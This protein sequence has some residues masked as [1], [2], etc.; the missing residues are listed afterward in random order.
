[1]SDSIVRPETGPGSVTHLI[2]VHCDPSTLTLTVSL[3]KIS[4]NPG[5][6]VVW[7]FLGIPAGWTPWIEFRQAEDN[8]FVGPLTG[9]TQTPGGIWGVCRSTGWPGTAPVP[10]DYRAMIQRGFADGWDT[11]GSIAWSAPARLDVLPS[12]IGQELFYNV[13]RDTGPEQLVV[14][15][16]QQTLGPSDVIVWHFPNDLP[17]GVEAW[18]PRIKL[19]RYEGTGTVVNEQLGP[20]AALTVLPGKLR[21]TG[22]SGVDGLYFFEV[23][24]VSVATGQ[25][26]W[27]S[28]GDPVIDNRGGVSTPD[29][30]KKPPRRGPGKPRT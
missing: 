7:S 22:N 4:L 23:A 9:L 2:P 14:E 18:R 28:S 3:P 12:A 27:M 1:M 24:L 5:D 13:T 25:I 15:P 21:G 10:F 20:F 11:Q 16:L 19:K 6:T 8:A 30:P 26:G 17:D 29:D